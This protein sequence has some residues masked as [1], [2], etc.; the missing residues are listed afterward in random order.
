MEPNHTHFLLFDDGTNEP[1]NI[2]CLRTG[3]ENYA[4]LMKTD[5]NIKDTI[6][7]IVMV[8]LE[9]GKTAAHSVYRALDSN[10]PVVVV[11]VKKNIVNCNVTTLDSEF[12]GVG[13]SSLGKQI[14]DKYFLSI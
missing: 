3:I 11:K 4:R 10:I 1:E 12:I 7:P 13:R 9:G 5:E 8:L 14:F 2:L 6:T